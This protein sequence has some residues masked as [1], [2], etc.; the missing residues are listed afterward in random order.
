M[1]ETICNFGP[2]GG[3]FGILTRPDDDV[4][5]ADSPV[6]IILNAGIVHRVGPFRLHVNLARQLAAQGFTTLRLDLSGLGDSAPRPGKVDLDQRAQLDISDAMD[7]L[8]K[9]LSGAALP[10]AN[11]RRAANSPPL[12]FTVIGLCSGAYEAHRIAVADE[13]IVGAVFL[14]GI[15]FRTLG[16]YFRT[17]A[18]YLKP[19]FW[20]N[21][22]K[23]RWLARRRAASEE[24][25]KSLAE[26][27]FFG[28]DLCR[29]KITDE[30]HELV[31]R[32]TQM[33]FLYTG[34]YDDICGRSQFQEMYGLQPSD[35]ANGST[36]EP[37]K[38]AA[39]GSRGG[40]LQVEYYD[41]AEHT[42]RL[43]ENRQLAC[44]RI[45]DWYQD[46]FAQPHT[47]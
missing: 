23:R 40:Q 19:R 22:I 41:R 39:G 32:N 38:T 31:R 43:T 34:G 20:R 35:R 37:S 44:R 13:R 26:S 8:E 36:D 24:P 9:E 15:V 1:N 10:F 47:V 11:S 46:R 30:L 12:R 4:K 21:A 25:G 6:A 7:F 33:L 14:D 17:S 45:V 28:G 16:F 5:V 2:G 27:E 29:K 42:F 3:L 18:R